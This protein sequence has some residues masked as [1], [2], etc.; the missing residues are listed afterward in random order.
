MEPDGTPIQYTCAPL[1][2]PLQ[3]REYFGYVVNALARAWARRRMREVRSC[4][5]AVHWHGVPDD[6]V[7]IIGQWSLRQIPLVHPTVISFAQSSRF[8]IAQIDGLSPLRQQWDVIRAMNLYQ[9]YVLGSERIRRGIQ[10]A[11]NALSEG[12]IFIAG[13]TLEKDAQRNDVTVFQKRQ[14]QAQVMERL[15]K[16]FEF[17]ALATAYRSGAAAR[18]CP[19]P[20]PV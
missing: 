2:L 5:S 19:D 16:G 6:Q 15:G 4:A 14:G 17:E 12:G 3:T 13:R 18:A 11:L 9:P 1:V 20:Q 7:V 10:A 8:H